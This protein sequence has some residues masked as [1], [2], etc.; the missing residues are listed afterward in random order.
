MNT[1]FTVIEGNLTRDPEIKEAGKSQVASFGLA[2]NKRVRDGND[3]K[4]GTPG[5]Y[6]VQTWNFMAERVMQL[7]K[8][9]SVI[10]IGQLQYESWEK[11]G[12][13]RNA[14]RINA[15]T[16]GLQL[17]KSDNVKTDN[18]STN[19]DDEIPFMWEDKNLDERRYHEARWEGTNLR[20]WGM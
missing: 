12:Q 17:R 3:W 14:V 13:K 7:S 10:V 20:L 8:G 1:N 2:V 6:E 18:K 19:D 5:F 4:D 11:D 16:V 9:A 15:Q